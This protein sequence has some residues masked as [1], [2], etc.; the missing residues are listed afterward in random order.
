M[1]LLLCLLLSLEA[2]PSAADGLES[3]VVNS[4]SLA[5]ACRLPSY[6][7]TWHGNLLFLLGNIV[8][9]R[10]NKASQVVFAFIYIP[11]LAFSPAKVPVLSFVKM[12][13]FAFSNN[14]F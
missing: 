5:I 13:T 6:S 4:F 1:K 8:H 11:R 2:W 7:L 3:E 14:K 12:G 10:L 9:C